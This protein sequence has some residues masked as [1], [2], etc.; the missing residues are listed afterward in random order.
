MV[1][2]CAHPLVP[3]LRAVPTLPN[4]RWNGEADTV[5]LRIAVWRWSTATHRKTRRK[6]SRTSYS[7]FLFLPSLLTT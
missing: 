2:I 5:G 3:P 6:A 4:A 7:G 1:G